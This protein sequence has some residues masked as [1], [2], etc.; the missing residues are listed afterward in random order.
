[1]MRDTLR[2]LLLVLTVA[3]LAMAANYYLDNYRSGRKPA[4]LFRSAPKSKNLSFGES[5]LTL[6]CKDSRLAVIGGLALT[7]DTQT[8]KEV[9]IA[10][11][12]N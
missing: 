2:D 4:F 9:E 5:Y 7:P 6:R 3:A 12:A 1:M 11:C 10:M 8:L